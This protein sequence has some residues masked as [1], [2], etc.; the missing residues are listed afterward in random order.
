[1][2][3][4]QSNSSNQAGVFTLLSQSVVIYKVN[5]NFEK[6]SSLFF[7]EKNEVKEIPKKM[8]WQTIPLAIFPWIS[9]VATFE[10]LSRFPKFLCDWSTSKSTLLWGVPIMAQRKQI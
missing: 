1:M 5:A 2:R 4:K 8:L 9:D 6:S 3:G 7:L 10:K